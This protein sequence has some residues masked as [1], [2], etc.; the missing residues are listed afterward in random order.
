MKRQVTRNGRILGGF[1]PTPVADAIDKWIDQG[2]ERD[3]STFIREAAREKLRRDGIPF[4]EK[5][6]VAA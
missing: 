1:V 3:K 2:S 5:Q 4:T 6:E